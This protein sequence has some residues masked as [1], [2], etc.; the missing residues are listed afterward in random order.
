MKKSYP[1]LG[2]RLSAHQ[3]RLGVDTAGM[4]GVDLAD[5]ISD[6]F[7]FFDSPILHPSICNYCITWKL[8]LV[9]RKRFSSAYHF[10][11]TPT[12]HALVMED[13]SPTTQ[14]ENSGKHTDSPKISKKNLSHVEIA[15]PWQ[16]G[17]RHVCHLCLVR[18]R[19]SQK[20]KCFRSKGDIL[21][22]HKFVLIF[23]LKTPV[24]R[25]KYISWVNRLC[26]IHCS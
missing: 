21:I 18:Y 22:S 19:L 10:H 23:H 13:L 6:L 20:S 4:W 17:P 11:L 25:W 12:Y 15:S 24:F 1:L 26:L 8:W 7:A 5:E 3:Q 14:T 2:I 9:L 16:H